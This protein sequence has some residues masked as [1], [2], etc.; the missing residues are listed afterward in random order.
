MPENNTQRIYLACG[1]VFL[2]IFSFAAI[3]AT[4]MFSPGDQLAVAGIIALIVSTWISQLAG[5]KL[6]VF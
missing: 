5:D 2:A 3:I 6:R 1:T 4:V